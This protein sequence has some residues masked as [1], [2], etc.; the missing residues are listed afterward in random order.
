MALNLPAAATPPIMPVG[1]N[2]PLQQLRLAGIFGQT[3]PNQPVPGSMIGQAPGGMVD[4]S[5]ELGGIDELGGSDPFGGY[6]PSYEMAEAFQEL[7]SNYPTEG[8]GILKKIALS[9]LG[10]KD[11]R[12]AASLSSQP[13]SA[14]QDW[15]AQIGP[16]QA[17][18]IQEGRSNTNLRML[19][20]QIL[21]GE[22]TGERLRLTGERQEE[23][24]RHNLATEAVQKYNSENPNQRI[25][26]LDDGSIVGVNPRNPTDV[27]VVPGAENL[28]FEEKEEL[29]NSGL[30][31]R[32]ERAEGDRVSRQKTGIE[33]GQE[34]IQ[35]RERLRGKR[36]SKPG[37]LSEAAKATRIAS[38]AQKLI[39]EHPDWANW[40]TID[41]RQVTVSPTGRKTGWFDLKLDKEGPTPEIRKQIMDA[42]YGNGVSPTEETN[43]GGDVRVVSPDGKAGTVPASQLEAALKEGYTKAP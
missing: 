3:P 30:L 22:Q 5:I 18:M 15:S 21:S 41:G 29:K 32:Y 19:A 27:T 10:A 31:E 7:L 23:T 37:M 8:H 25:I 13:T 43:T 1:G 42:I 14:Q 26:E 35:E 24:G 28:S 6:D 36:S 16:A 40:I 2:D 17:S 20:D 33:A 12:L 11:P 34:N 39:N 4:P 38:R 9:M